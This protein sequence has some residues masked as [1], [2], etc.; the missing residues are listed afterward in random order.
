MSE[1]ELFSLIHYALDAYGRDK[2]DSYISS[3]VSDKNPFF[4]GIGSA[5][6]IVYEEY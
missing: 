1:F 4:D 5:D 2:E 3:V 6:S